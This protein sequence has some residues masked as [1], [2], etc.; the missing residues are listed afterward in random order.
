MKRAICDTFLIFLSLSF[1]VSVK[2]EH[3]SAVS[4][5]IIKVPDDYGTIQEA[6]NASA[7]GDII[8][9]YNGTYHEH[10]EINKS[11][12]LVGQS[13]DIT[14]IDGDG[15]G[16]IVHV[17]EENVSVSGFTIRNGEIGIHLQNCS[18]AIVKENAIISNYFDGIRIT[19]SQN[20]TI[21]DNNIEK[22]SQNCIFLQNSDHSSLDHNNITSN[23]RMSQGILLYYSNNNIISCNTVRGAAP[24]GNEGG[25]G[26]LYSNNNTVN[27]NFIIYNNW[28]GISLR[29]SNNT[30]VR[31]NTIVK[32][33]WF[34]MRLGYSYN[35][36]IYHNNFINNCCQ[37][38]VES[39]NAAWDSAGLGNYWSD[40]FGFDD[41]S[42]GI[43]DVPYEI[44]NVNIDNFPLIGK[45]YSF[46]V[47]EESEIN[48][49]LIISNSTIS[50]F[51]FLTY[52]DSKI[53]QNVSLI[54][55]NLTVNAESAGFCRITIPHELLQGPYTVFVDNSPPTT[56]KELTSN[57]THT[58][59]YF[60]YN[61][62]S[63][64]VV[65]VPEFLR[66]FFPPLFI[67]L[68][69]LS[70]IITRN[71]KGGKE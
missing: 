6:I 31:G 28:C 41:D 47:A 51:E 53:D 19:S 67:L 4:S 38:S 43:G 20:I 44:D 9:V 52:F 63:K 42:D 3:V 71:K 7:L 69:L 58:T 46:L 26:L 64:Y 57:I 50:D 35:N 18:D 17:S 29:Y 15:L 65:I 48:Q 8:Y 13:P 32:H 59:L 12:S 27:K 10:L 14:I 1:F 25:I 60:S 49:V 16:T 37:A 70:I 62:S 21:K 24:E 30:I 39:A 54:K 61:R 2:T 22:I 23:S 56:M 34:G 45:F 33:K 11:V 5:T 40:Y 66:A 36:H 55:V 68:S